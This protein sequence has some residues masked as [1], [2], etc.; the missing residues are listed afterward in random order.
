[1]AELEKKVVN[2]PGVQPKP[3]YP[4]NGSYDLP[5]ETPEEKRLRIRTATE[6]LMASMFWKE[7]QRLKPEDQ[8][9]YAENE[10][11]LVDYLSEYF[12]RTGTVHS[13]NDPWQEISDTVDSIQEKRSTS[14]DRQETELSRVYNGTVCDLNVPRE[15]AYEAPPKS[16]EELEEEEKQD[17]VKLMAKTFWR[18][19]SRLMPEDQE[20][21]AERSPEVIDYLAEYFEE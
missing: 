7:W 10:P 5:E 12:D 9:V 3:R 16:K 15:G 1:M 8:E 6:K 2:I 17:Q 14:A 4:E 13:G 18:E 19:W 20:V 21:F 11:E